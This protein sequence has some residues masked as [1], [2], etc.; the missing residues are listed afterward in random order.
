MSA[1]S[2]LSWALLVRIF[3][4]KS[5]INQGLLYWTK[6]HHSKHL[7]N[8]H[9]NCSY[10]INQQIL[11][12]LTAKRIFFSKA[13]I[14]RTSNY[15]VEIYSTTTID[16]ALKSKPNIKLLL[17]HSTPCLVI[18]LYKLTAA[19]VLCPFQLTKQSTVIL[20]LETFRKFTGQKVKL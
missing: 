16:P 20:V 13:V 10:Q 1:R 6:N 9:L 14:K 4:S 18:A 8:L 11:A 5:K 3:K 17:I 7:S 19:K 12:C 15:Q 2:K